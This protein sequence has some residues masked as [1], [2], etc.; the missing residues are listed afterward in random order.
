MQSDVGKQGRRDSALPL[1][2]GPHNVGVQAQMTDI[3]KASTS[4]AFPRAVVAGT[5]DVTTHGTLT[6]LV[7]KQ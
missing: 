1:S 3:H 2:A 6:A 7:L 5:P 4:V